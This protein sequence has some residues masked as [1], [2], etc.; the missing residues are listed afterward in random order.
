MGIQVATIG[1]NTSCGS[2]KG[3]PDCLPLGPASSTSGASRGAQ[4][5]IPEQIPNEDLCGG[6]EIV[7]SAAMARTNLLMV[8]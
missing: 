4:I 6:T 3:G 2:S 7:E 1:L 8:T 5:L